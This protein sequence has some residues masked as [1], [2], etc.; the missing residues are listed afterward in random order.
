MESINKR[1][2]MQKLKAYKRNPISLVLSL[3]VM[4][5]TILTIGI[6]VAR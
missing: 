3:L 4:L 2:Y 5:S 1:S 6:F